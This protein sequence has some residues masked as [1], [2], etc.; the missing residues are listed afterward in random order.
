LFDDR[1]STGLPSFIIGNGKSL[2]IPLNGR[3][4]NAP[5]E[6]SPEKS[7]DAGSMGRLQEIIIT[8]HAMMF[9][10]SPFD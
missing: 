4:S 6:A 10:M 5:A 2:G 3:S 8:A 1:R 9:R 7:I